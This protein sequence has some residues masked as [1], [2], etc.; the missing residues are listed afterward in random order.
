[1]TVFT[2]SDRSRSII[3]GGIAFDPSAT[4]LSYRDGAVGANRFD[5]RV[6]VRGQRL[7]LGFT[8]A[9]AG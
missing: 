1:V 9:Q 8:V 6:E 4:E 5:G 2:R 7:V 3:S